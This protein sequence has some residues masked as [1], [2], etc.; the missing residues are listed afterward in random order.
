MITTVLSVLGFVSANLPMFI[1][2]GTDVVDMFD[3]GTAL[4]SSD[5]T[6]TPAERDA[7]VAEIAG[8]R[9]QFADRLEELR[10]QAP[11]S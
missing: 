9:A 3:K 1:A 7:A 6:S 4:V 10:Q 11:S 2:L 5:T 8:M